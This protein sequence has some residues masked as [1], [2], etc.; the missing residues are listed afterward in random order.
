MIQEQKTCFR[1]QGPPH[2]ADVTALKEMSQEQRRESCPN[3]S[4]E[5]KSP[6]LYQCGHLI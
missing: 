1:A 2:G 5:S 6:A 3:I 4:A